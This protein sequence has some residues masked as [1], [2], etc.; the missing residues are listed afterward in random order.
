MAWFRI[1]A[2]RHNHPVEI[3]FDDILYVIYAD[4]GEH[5]DIRTDAMLHMRD[6]Q[7]FRVDPE[8]W[9]RVLGEITDVTEP[10]T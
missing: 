1:A 7:E 8:K 10:T 3:N 6:G 2:G 9:G 5:P 4:V